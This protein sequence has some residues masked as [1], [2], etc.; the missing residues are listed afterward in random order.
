[1]NKDFLTTAQAAKRAGTSRPTVSRAL[2]N[3]DLHAIRDNAGRW[4]ITAEAVD[5]WA[6]DR[7]RVQ[8]EQRANSVH[9][10]PVAPSNEHLN[11]LEQ[12]RAD[13]TE[14]REKIARLEGEAGA[15]K[16]RISDLMRDRDALRD[17]LARAASHPRTGFWSR[18][19]RR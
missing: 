16:D 1:M 17:A 7:S 13:L 5:A 6:E 10:A 4:I 2:K 9:V 18:V 15:N 12:A 11:A 3:G 19:F 8:D 14:A